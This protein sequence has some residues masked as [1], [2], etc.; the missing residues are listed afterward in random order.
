VNFE[1]MKLLVDRLDE[2]D[3][4][5]EVVDR[6]DP[7]DLEATGSIRDFVTN[8]RTSEHRSILFGPDAIAKS[9][10]DAPL[11]SGNSLPPS[12]PLLSDPAFL[13]LAL[14]SKCP[15]ARV[16]N[17]KPTHVYTYAAGHLEL[18]YALYQLFIERESRLFT[19]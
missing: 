4:T 15:P 17:W 19:A 5:R 14:H 3:A 1:E 10:L 12:Q 18:L 6:S 9:V 7:A 8:A 16:M 13:Y 2:P 11:S